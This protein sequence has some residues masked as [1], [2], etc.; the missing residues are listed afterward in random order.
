MVQHPGEFIIISGG[1]YHAGF[2]WGFNVAEAVN[3]A[4][5][6]WMEMLPNADACRCVGDSVKIDKIDFFNNILTNSKYNT[7]EEVK[8]ICAEHGVVKCGDVVVLPE[9]EKEKEPE[10]ADLHKKSNKKPNNIK[11]AEDA[12][13]NAKQEYKE[14]KKGGNTKGKAYKKKG[15]LREGV[16]LEKNQNESNSGVL[17]QSK[18]IRRCGVMELKENPKVKKQGKHSWNET[19]TM[20]EEMKQFD[21]EKS[22]DFEN[23]VSYENESES[24]KLSFEEELHG[25]ESI[26]EGYL[27][28]ILDMQRSFLN[29]DSARCLI[30]AIVPDNEF[31]CDTFDTDRM[32][33]SQS[34]LNK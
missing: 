32:E 9:R 1:A 10:T 29:E 22:T 5:V 19:R 14:Y 24:K 15:D 33:I 34:A 7:I 23:A 18:K 16:L 13:K 27:Q 21:F 30:R 25:K 31:M 26:Q 20:E 11:S 2:N 17:D 6:K 8:R 28:D 4:T 12:K 3:F